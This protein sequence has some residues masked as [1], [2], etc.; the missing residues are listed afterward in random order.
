M[1]CCLYWIHDDIKL[2]L[3]L[4]DD[5]MKCSTYWSSYRTLE[6]VADIFLTVFAIFVV[7]VAETWRE[8]EKFQAHRKLFKFIFPIL[9]M[10][11]V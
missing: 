2:F 3:E 5:D 6:N 1:F 4:P 8:S 9:V 7:M 11:I 10:Y